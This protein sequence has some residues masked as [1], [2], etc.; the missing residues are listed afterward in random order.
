[1]KRVIMAVSIIGA[2]MILSDGCKKTPSVDV[3]NGITPVSDSLS[4]IRT[5]LEDLV[6]LSPLERTARLER[7]WP[8]LGED[9]MFYARQYNLIPAGSQVERIE[10][11]FGSLDHVRANDKQ[12]VQHDGHATN[13]LIAR[14][15]LAGVSAPV[16][17]FVKCLNGMVAA[18]ADMDRLQNVIT[19]VPLQR[20]TIEPRQ[21]LVT[22][23]DYPLAISLAEK[24]NLPL[25][26]GR[27]LDAAN[28]ISPAH[29]RA[30]EPETA[31]VQITVKVFAGDRFDLIAGTYT[32]APQ[33]ADV[34]HRHRI[35]RGHKKHNV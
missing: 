9:V 8:H 5:T 13:Q 23:V 14:V 32:P 1:M 15:H 7:D 34:H 30:M 11:L 10:F 2:M 21:G 18:S 26:A 12:G 25:Y 35:K 4:G 16:D 3:V 24:F 27:K 28:L 17:L 19:S 6:Q 22:Y 29:A 31:R 33:P 20:F